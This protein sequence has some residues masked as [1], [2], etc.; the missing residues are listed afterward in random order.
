MRL[1]ESLTGRNG[2][3]EAAALT[4]ARIGEDL[5]RRTIRDCAGNPEDCREW[6]A[7]IDARGGNLVGDPIAGQGS[8]TDVG[9]LVRAMDPRLEYVPVH[10]H[11]NNSSVSVQDADLLLAF[12]PIALVAVIGLDGA[13]HLLRKGSRPAARETV[14]TTYAAE[15]QRLR[16]L[17]LARQRVEELTSEEIWRLGSHEVWANIATTLGLAYDR[18]EPEATR[19]P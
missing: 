14:A 17:Y 8:Q 10:T 7:A 2:C 3:S 9:V 11:P 5:R 15:R 16:P 1:R 13:W 19:D 18:I 4:V 6:A 12:A